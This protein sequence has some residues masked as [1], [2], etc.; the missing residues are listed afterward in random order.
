MGWFLFNGNTGLK[1]ANPN[2]H[3]EETLFPQVSNLTRCTFYKIIKPRIQT[4]K[5]ASNSHKQFMFF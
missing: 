1:L 3:E 2:H 5:L 4:E